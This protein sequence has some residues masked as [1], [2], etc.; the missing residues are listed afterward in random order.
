MNGMSQQKWFSFPL[1]KGITPLRSHTNSYNKS[2]A[3]L[4]AEDKKSGVGT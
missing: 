1:N 4:G 2:V 3:V